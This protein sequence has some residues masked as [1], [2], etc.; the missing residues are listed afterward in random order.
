[1]PSSPA[2]MMFKEP[3]TEPECPNS[4]AGGR[5]DGRLPQP[6]AIAG[7]DRD[8]VV[9]SASSA[10]GSSRPPSRARKK[11]ARSST[12]ETVLRA[13]RP[14]A[15]AG[16]APVRAVQDRAQHDAAFGH[17]IDFGAME[18]SGGCP[19][20]AGGGRRVLLRGVL[21]L[22]VAV[23]WFAA[24]T[25]SGH[26]Q[27]VIAD[28]PHSPVNHLRGTAVAATTPSFTANLRG[29]FVTASNTLLT[30]PA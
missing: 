15:P 10:P 20:T 16:G 8:R 7:L 25:G 13:P 30:C 2:S 3:G 26:A 29:D 5:V 17:V 12:S 23:L 4:R 1:M 9:I 24:L 14:T 28:W 11:R 19:T 27:T 18:P 6:V 21:G 22:A